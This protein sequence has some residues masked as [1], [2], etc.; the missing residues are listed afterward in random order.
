M[1]SSDSVNP[2]QSRRH[3]IVSSAMPLT[4]Q[5]LAGRY[6]VLRQLGSGGMGTVYLAE[7]IHLGRP[8]AI[9]LLRAE[10]CCDPNAE[11]RF[12]REA[13]LA[14][15]LMHPAVAQIYDFDRTDEGQF[16]IAMEYVDGETVAQRLKR[17]GPFPVPMALHILR[18]VAEGLDRAHA[19]GIVHRDIKPENVM[20]ASGGV[21]KLLDFGVARDIDVSGAG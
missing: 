20:L 11:A 6:R 8:T 9:K 3:F 10:L 12:R 16:L 1:T 18:G 5:T 14:A 21:V 4:G 7:H 15:R 13:L 2:P 17:E 19:L